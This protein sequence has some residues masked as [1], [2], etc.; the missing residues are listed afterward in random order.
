[1]GKFCVFDIETDSLKPNRIHC[2]SFN[3]YIDGEWKSY[4]TTEYDV[5]KKIFSRDDLV[6]VGHN[7]LLFDIPAVEKILGVKVE[8]EYIDTMYLSQYLYDKEESHS[9][10]AWG[11]KLKV[12]KRH[13]EDEM[14]DPFTEEEWAKMD[15]DKK[16]QDQYKQYLEEIYI[17]RCDRDV[18]INT[19][20]FKKFLDYLSKLYKG[21][22]DHFVKY[23]TFIISN[24]QLQ[25]SNMWKLDVPQLESNLKEL[26]ERY[27]SYK[28]ELEGAM[29]K[30][31]KMKWANKPKN[32][33]KKNGD[34]SAAGARW[35][36]YLKEAGLPEDCEEE[37]IKVFHKME[38]PNASSP[39]QIKDWL[40]SLGWEPDYYKW[41]Q[42]TAG[43]TNIVPQVK[44]GS[45]L[46]DSVLLLAERKEEVKLLETYTVLKSRKESLEGFERN[47]DCEGFIEA[48]IKGVTSTLR[49]RHSTIV[50]LPGV[51]KLYGDY[52]RGVLI[53]RPGHTLCGSDLN[54]LE[55]RCK[56]HWIKPIDPEY[57]AS[58]SDTFYDPHLDI[59]I[60]S[61]EIS[62]EEVNFYK[63]MDNKDNDITF[64]ID[65]VDPFFFH[66]DDNKKKELYNQIKAMRK[67][68]KQ[69]NYSAVYGIKPKSLGRG[70]GKGERWAEKV[71]DTYW[72]R[73][74]A[75][76]EVE[77]AAKIVQYGNQS[78]V[79]NEIN[80][81]WYPLRNQ[82]D[83]FSA[84][85]QGL[86]AYIFNLWIYFQRKMGL[87]EY[88]GQF[89]D[90][91]ILDIPKGREDHTEEVLHKSIDLVNKKLK[92][93]VDMGCTVEFGHRYSE[94]H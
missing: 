91:V 83:I 57:V 30:V 21:D 26:K 47:M 7:I 72:R 14:W 90:E 62:E 71:L 10:E 1:M 61:G 65:R 52:V 32:I 9:L 11:R 34:L 79:F 42:N 6:W 45:E 94:I 39:N 87:T 33:W 4:T 38:E 28:E 37:K 92:L 3:T 93:N 58:M 89:H 84:L 67:V 15:H 13:V 64:P 16:L 12:P 5:M 43:E 35:F 50:N 44:K 80:K 82:K 51:D 75:V 41:T 59:A 85:N 88:V 70:T 22:F 2:A 17:P 19:L 86:G 76:K 29:P 40:F 77:K 54:S 56:Q 48:D 20:I 53:S 69:V 25:K 60:L 46:S 78:W 63:W 49:M 24:V 27:V 8:G 66:I 31:K 36:N 18:E 55:D 23:L 68:Y 81:I 73:N 74:W